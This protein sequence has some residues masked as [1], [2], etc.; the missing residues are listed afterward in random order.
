MCLVNRIRYVLPTKTNAEMGNHTVISITLTF[1]QGQERIF[2]I[3]HHNNQKLFYY[4]S[5]FIMKVSYINLSF[6]TF[7]TNLNLLNN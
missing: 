6:N 3:G 1:R 5:L 2:G 4:L 7:I